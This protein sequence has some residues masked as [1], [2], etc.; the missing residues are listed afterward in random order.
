MHSFFN[1][2]IENDYYIGKNP[3]KRIKAQDMPI[4]VIPQHHE[5]MILANLEGEQYRIIKFL[6]MTGFRISEALQL[7]WGDIDWN[8]NIILVNNIKGKRIDYF[9]LYPKLKEF[10]LSFY[11]NQPASDK[12]FAYS[13]RTSMKFFRRTLNKL[14]LPPY[15]IH[16]IRKTFASRY[17]EKLTAKETRE[18]L[19]HRDIRT[20][21][22]YYVKVDLQAIGDKLG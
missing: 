13:N 22:K 6:F 17:A 5:E 15:T 12:V 11:H 1:W 16:S 4:T 8:D 10:L 7:H 9:P 3:I 14:N 18:I 2:L 20:T 21:L 19:R